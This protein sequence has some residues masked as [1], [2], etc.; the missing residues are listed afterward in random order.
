MAKSVS[1]HELIEAIAGAVISA[2]DLIEKNQ[3]TKVR[4]YFHENNRPV[5]V[6]IRLP[7]INYVEEPP[8]DQVDQ[9]KSYEKQQEIYVSVP[10]LSL[11]GSSSLHIKGMDVE[12]DVDLSGF[13]ETDEIPKEG[14]TSSEK[15]K[16][17]RDTPV[18]GDAKQ[19]GEPS[20]DDKAKEGLGWNSASKLKSVGV[21]WQSASDRKMAHLSL[22]VEAK[23]TEGMARL[24][25]RLNQMIS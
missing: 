18:G 16:K 12:F 8:Y 11:V 14:E 22:R 10:I 15:D 2:Q 13:G 3:T 17:P 5:C 6:N 20:G 9:R 19:G 24:I 4:Q 7:N 23:E 25:Q 1:L 21:D